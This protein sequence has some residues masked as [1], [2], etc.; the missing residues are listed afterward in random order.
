MQI[1]FQMFTA[2]NYMHKNKYIHRDLKPENILVE[3]KPCGEEFIGIKISDF[4][5][6]TYF[7]PS[8]KEM[9]SI[10]TPQYMAPE[11]V[12]GNPYGEKVDIWSA[13][14]IAYY[15]LSGELPF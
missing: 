10:G 6:A 12:K 4:G 5:F 11:I 3:E 2:I 14:V 1:C 7:R 8:E 15:L 13:G 9:T